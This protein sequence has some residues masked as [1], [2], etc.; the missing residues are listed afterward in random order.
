VVSTVIFVKLNTTDS[1]GLEERI[2][3]YVIVADHN[4]LQGE[5]DQLN[6][7]R[8][9]LR[10]Y[11]RS[12]GPAVTASLNKF[13]RQASRFRVITRFVT[14]VLAELGVLPVTAVAPPTPK[15]HACAD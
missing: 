15:L 3:G 7:I 12:Q 8:V 4:I 11:H 6:P 13:T 5:L 10:N 14:W 9:L 1:A 2:A